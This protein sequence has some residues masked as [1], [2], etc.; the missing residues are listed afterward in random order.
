MLEPTTTYV[1]AV[2]FAATLIRSTLGFGEA[3]VAVPLLAL[4]I[5]VSVAAPLAV[6]V[7]VVV[8]AIIVAQDWRRIEVRSAVW[9]LAAALPGI[10]LGLLL[11]TQVNDRI[12]KLILGLII[13]AFSSYS[14]AAKG[15]F[16]LLRDHGGMLLGCG[17][18][19]GI[20]GGAYGMNG[21]PLAVYGTL[22]R[23]SPQHFRATLQGY[24]LPA[25]LLGLAGYAALGLWGAE[26]TRYFLVSL[27]GVLAAIFLGR[28]LN[29]RVSGNG[30]LRMTYGGLILIGA[31]LLIQA[32]TG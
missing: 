5:P 27:P 14:L 15:R 10:P 1:L 16:H 24:F 7:S 6:L 8:A 19:S 29:H 12:V 23:W 2:L 13:I 3:L 9:L 18:C 22:R 28:A 17:F 26:V 30:F 21:P 25:S 4:R 32:Y 20:L 11:L 31:V